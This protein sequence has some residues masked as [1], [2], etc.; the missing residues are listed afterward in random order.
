MLP[1]STSN[2]FELLTVLLWQYVIRRY[3]ALIK[4]CMCF[5]KFLAVFKL[6]FCPSCPILSSCPT[7]L[8]CSFWFFCFHCER[9]WP[10]FVLVPFPLAL[11]IHSVFLSR[12]LFLFLSPD[13]FCHQFLLLPPPPPPFS[14]SPSNPVASSLLYVVLKKILHIAKMQCMYSHKFTDI[15]SCS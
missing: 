10:I 4:F 5:P 11:S 3:D 14:S 13:L 9:I 15:V 7:W 1:F 2:F 6:D 8:H 12:S